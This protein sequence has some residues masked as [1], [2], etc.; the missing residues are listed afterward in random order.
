MSAAALRPQKRISALVGDDLEDT[1]RMKKKHL[2]QT[3][4]IVPLVAAMVFHL[5]SCRRTS[6]EA[7]GAPPPEVEVVAVEQKDIPVYRDW[8]G[9][10][11]GQVNAAIRSQVT[12]YLLTLDYSEGSLVNK[13]QL[14]FQIDP[15]P[16]QAAADQARGQLA[17]ATG[18]LAKAQA[19]YQQSEAQLASAEAN[20]RKAQFDED[21]YTPLA[22]ARAVTQQD[23]DNAVQNNISA[24]AQVKVAAAQVEAAKAQIQAATAAVEAA[25]ASL[26]AANVNLGFTKLYSPIDGI[27]G[28]AQTQIGNLVSP[29]SNVVTTV[30]TLDPIKVTFAVSEQEYLRLSKQRKPTDPV[31]PLELILADGTVHPYEGRF[32]FTGRQVSQGTGAIEATGLF[33]NPGSILR[34]GQYGKV[35]VP[36]ETLHSA[37]LVPQQAVSELQGSFQVAIVDHNNAVN[38]QVIKVGDQIG[39]SWVILD[40]LNPGDRVIVDGIQKVTIGM[41]VNPKASSQ[42]PGA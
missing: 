39:S 19:Q 23:L 24:K 40:G 26:E 7:V 28:T 25:K 18:Q 22:K 15:R 16:L 3:Y 35:R 6:A 4:Q 2:S 33:P 9:T 17:Q 10:L 38:I 32:A 21:R 1:I 29:A 31:P 34:P 5:T 42:K 36:V 20:Q 8:I 11:D 37:L 12:G 41:R 14:L 13:G 30:S 27:A